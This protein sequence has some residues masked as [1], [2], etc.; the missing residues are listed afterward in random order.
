MYCLYI[1]FAILTR[2]LSLI[3]LAST[4]LATQVIFLKWKSKTCIVILQV[5]ID[6]ILAYKQLGVQQLREK[7]ERED[8]DNSRCLDEVRCIVH[9]EHEIIIIFEMFC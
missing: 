4:S 2:S 7:F 8:P 5:L 3:R 1:G 6:L 9:Q